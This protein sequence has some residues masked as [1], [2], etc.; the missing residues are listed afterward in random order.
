MSIKYFGSGGDMVKI[1]VD[2]P[3]KDGV[4]GFDQYAAALT[5]III[6]S[7][8]RFVVG[9]FGGWGVG[10]TTLMT[11]VYESLKDKD[12][13]VPLWFNA[14]RYEREKY[15]A[16]IPLLNTILVGIS[17]RTELKDFKEV[18]VKIIRSLAKGIRFPLIP[19]YGVIELDVNQMLRET[20]DL[21]KITHSDIIYYDELST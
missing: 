15:S 1:L 17:E 14:W 2:E 12:D 8:P 20:A 11:M 18:L 10:K 13:V 9:V 21:K 5:N 7:D 4:L 6:G 3:V 16:V 19:I